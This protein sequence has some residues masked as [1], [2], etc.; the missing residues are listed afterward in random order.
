MI[1][2]LNIKF[3]WKYSYLNIK[4]KFSQNIINK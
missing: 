1:K 4:N 2:Y 3:K